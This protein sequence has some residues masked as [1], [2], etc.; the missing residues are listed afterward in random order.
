MIRNSVKRKLSENKTVLGSFVTQLAPDLTEI[1]ALSGFDFVVIDGEHSPLGPE[2]A[3]GIIR[4]AE[5]RGISPLV[6]VP[7]ALESTVKHF[8]DIGAHGIQIPQCNSGDMA[9][10]I[11]RYAKY[12]PVGQRGV[13]FPRSADF[14][15]TDTN[16]YWEYE[17]N[18]TLVI[19]QCESVEGLENLEDICKVPEVDIIFLGPFDMSASMGITGQIGDPRITTAAKKVLDLTA[20]YGKNAGV[21]AMNGEA[22]RTRRKEGFRYI[23]V[24]MD[25]FL[26][27]A[28]CT[29]IVKEFR[30]EK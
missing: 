14:G 7:N 17:N 30:E 5:Y 13:A 26:F 12:A 11:I 24:G 15:I 21:F 19:C 20:K 29:E 28:K 18:E 4:A 23:I 9:K 27:S 22:A 25:T 8:L 3:Q 1:Y 6:R 2:S 10:E 16:A